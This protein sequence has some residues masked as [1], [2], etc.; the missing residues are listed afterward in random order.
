MR[1]DSALV[2]QNYCIIYATYLVKICFK[3]ATIHM[4]NISF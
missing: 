4:Y 2:K 3:S 1:V